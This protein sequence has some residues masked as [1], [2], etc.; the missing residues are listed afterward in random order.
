MD[1][2][3][4][5]RA[6]ALHESAQELEQRLS[7]VDQQLIEMKQFEQSIDF[8]ENMDEK[9][10]LAPLGKGVFA[11]TMIN[12]EQLFVDVG[13]GVIL[14]KEPKAVRAILKDQTQRLEEMRKDLVSQLNV[15]SAQ[16]DELS[17]IVDRS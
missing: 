2:S 8:I 3:F 17:S 13:A 10:M 6:Q 9:E 5:L 15:L 7:F 1:K 16:L 4:L 11:K 14:Q 12:K